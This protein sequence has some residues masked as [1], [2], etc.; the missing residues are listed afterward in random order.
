MCELKKKCGRQNGKTF[1]SYLRCW[2]GSLPKNEESIRK[3]IRF[4]DKRCWRRIMMYHSLK[5]NIRYDHAGA[6][7]V[8]MI[9]HNH[10]NNRP[11]DHLQILMNARLSPSRSS[12]PSSI[13]NRLHKTFTSADNAAY[14]MTRNCWFHTI[15]N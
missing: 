7:K 5:Y 14:H 4:G 10:L 8:M 3:E 12:K 13:S 2:L 15:G 1:G 6:K 9:L 11:G